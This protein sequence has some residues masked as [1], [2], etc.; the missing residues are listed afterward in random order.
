M[1]KTGKI[2]A[3]A[4]LFC[5][6]SGLW[7][8]QIVS[9][10][11][12]FA[13]ANTANVVLTFDASQGNAGLLGE[14][15]I[16]AHTGV[17][18]NLSTSS[19]DWKYVL[20]TWTTNLPKA[21]LTRIGSS[22]KYTLNIGNI[23][24]YYG[25]PANEQILKLAI[26]FRNSDGSKTGKTS[27]GG[28]IFLDI[29]Q[30][31]F[32]VKLNSPAKMS[33][34]NAA[35][36]VRFIASASQTC[37]LKLFAN[38]QLVDSLYSDSV[39]LL[40]RLFSS[41]GSNRINLVLMGEVNGEKA[42]DSSYIMER[43]NPS[44]VELPAGME[45]GINYIN[46][47][48]VL[49]K[50]YAPFKNFIYVIGDFNNWELSPT[51]FMN[52]SSDG[53]HFWLSIGGLEKGKE[54]A[55]QYSIDQG[56]MKVADVYAEKL[57]DPYNDS[58][59]LPSTYPNLKPYPVGKTTEVVSV[60]QTARVPYLWKSSN[61]K[62]P[63]AERLVVYEMLLRDFIGKHDFKTLKDT[64]GYLKKLGVNCIELMP[65]MEFEGNESWGYNPMFYFAL[66]KYYGTKA[67]LQAFV[68]ACHQEN[69]AVVLDIALNHSFGQNPQVR[70]YFDAAAGLYGEPTANNPWFNQV[71]KHPFGVGYDYNHNAQPTRDFVD[72]VIKFWITEYKIDGYRF[73]L[74]KGFTQKNSGSD[75]GAWSAFDQGRLDIW[76]RIRGEILKYSPDAYLIL[77]HLGDN[78]EEKVLA[79]SG[80]IMWGKM[81]ESY[82]ESMM[83]YSNS[84]ANLSWGNYKSRG[85]SKP[86]LVTYAES[87][88]EE[89]VMFSCLTY[90]NANANYSTKTLNT[91]LRRVAAYHALL[92]PL[93]GPKMLWQGGE[94]GYEV[95]INT[96][97]RLGNKPFKWDY[98]NVPERL[99]VRNEIALLA[100]LKQHV[101]L[102]SNNYDYNVSGVIKTLK[103]T[104]DSMNTVIAGNF[105]VVAGVAKPVFQHTGWWY[106]YIYG[107]SI[108]VLDVNQEVALKAGDYKVFTDK[109][110]NQNPLVTVGLKQLD[111]NELVQIYPNP[112]QGIMY[113]DADGL[114]LEEAIL[115]DLNGKLVGA[116]GLNQSAFSHKIN[117]SDIQPGLY[118]LK[119][120]S[121][122]GSI[123]K[124]VLIGSN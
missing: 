39:L 10:S 38:N 54:Y 58:Y 88:D 124:K 45:N 50:I 17:I 61:Y 93:R 109:K 98:L 122:Q 80:F 44:I 34:Y 69:M 52:K 72:R 75:V 51:Y 82:A 8:Q 16:Y 30:G 83:G 79:D 60:L 96:N 4:F 87:H 74:S 18:T 22:N 104:H 15:I 84:K 64:L 85:F 71:D 24:S 108:E 57:L 47:T 91:A 41:L 112:A 67:D 33:F 95:S 106:N 66:D 100:A 92:L 107:D 97:G 25:V 9:I 89:R 86:N 5:F 42:F 123:L 6:A 94:L 21:L 14:S 27:S 63:E 3:I 113:I 1:K 119:L 23:R 114:L 37:T 120:K 40:N 77:E 115:F 29:N 110:I 101:S 76:N 31:V 49:L 43:R 103:V 28:D 81:T 11:P 62:K 65:I 99:A 32:Q 56:L 68:D 2:L 90:G 53:L 46:D 111:K 78:Q 36:T 116:F 73:D 117:V 48:A 35:D 13:N 12:A 7:A 19:S 105:D 102:G 70:M 121:N 59:I 20:T 26:V 55:F 118:F